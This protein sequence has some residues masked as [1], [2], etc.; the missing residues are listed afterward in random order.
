[1]EDRTYDRLI[2]TAKAEQILS[3]ELVHVDV[4]TL[5]AHVLLNRSDKEVYRW[6]KLAVEGGGYV[7]CSWYGRDKRT[8]RIYPRKGELPFTNVAHPIILKSL[9]S[10][11][12][13]GK[14]VCI[15]YSNHE[16]RIFTELFNIKNVPKDIHAYAS[17]LLGISRDDVKILNNAMIYGSDDDMKTRAKSVY[18]ASDE[19]SAREYL[20]LVLKLRSKMKEFT[21]DNLELFINNKY[22]FN[23]YGRKVYPKNE[24]SIFNNVIQSVGSEILIDAILALDK[25]SRGK[26]WNVI[27]QRF[28][29]VY[30]DFSK[31]A[32]LGNDLDEV[33]N[34]MIGVNPD[35]DLSAKISIGDNMENMK[36]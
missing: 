27:F 2:A 12:D 25:L 15:D 17:D 11:Y 8:Y 16:Y 1:M 19:K 5:R 34:T 36:E 24:S 35:I 32:L 26:K 14:I 13:D 4:N 31:E 10:R 28:D 7:K 22:I 30:F 6:L 33:Y 9:N 3:R 23:H 18:E 21:E 29:S 20:T